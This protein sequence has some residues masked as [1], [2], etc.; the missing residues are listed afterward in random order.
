MQHDSSPA[1][2]QGTTGNPRFQHVVSKDLAGNVIELPGGMSAE[3]F[4]VLVAFEREQQHDI[5]GW[6][7]GL[8]LDGGSTPWIELPV[9]DNPGVVG[10]WFI[11]NGM[12]RGIANHETWKHVVTLYTRKRDFLKQ[13]GIA[14]ESSVYALVVDRDGRILKSVQGPVTDKGAEEINAALTRADAAAAR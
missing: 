7:K 2:T 11:D 3:R 4:V 5:D 6:V 9:I 10:R 14:S 13:V 1:H 12:R 8:Q